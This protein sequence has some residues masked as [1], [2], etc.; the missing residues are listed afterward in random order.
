MSGLDRAKPHQ[1]AAADRSPG[2]SAFHAASP[3]RRA[4]SFG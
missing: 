3:P 4:A 1:P 2:R